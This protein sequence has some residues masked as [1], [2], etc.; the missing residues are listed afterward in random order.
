M[1]AVFL[2][3]LNLSITASW[4]ILAVV[5]ARFILKKA[6]K[7]VSCVLWTLV[8][9]RLVCPFTLESALSLIPSSETIPSNIEMMQK[10]AIDSG[11]T[12]IN[13]AINPVIA[14]HY[15]PDP[16]TS[17]N[18]LQ[19]IIPVLSIVW[20]VGMATMLLYALISYIRLKKSVGASVSVRDN[21]LACDE[22]KS[23]FIL[24]IIKPLIYVP[25]SM[26]GETLDYVITHE[27]AHIKR[28][29]HW[30]KPFGFLLLAIYWFN[31]LCWLA[32]ILLCRDIEMACDEKVIRDMDKGKVAEYS[33]ALLDCSFPRKMISACPLAFGEVGVK[34]RVKSVLNYKKPAFWIITVAVVTCIVISVCFLTNPYSSNKIDDKMK[35]T[36]DT[37]IADH[38]KSASNDGAYL[39]CAYDIFGV[40][41]RGNE[42][43]VYAWVVYEE[44][45]YENNKING[46]SGS[47]GPVV[48][49]V[50]TFQN[51]GSSSYKVMEYWVPRDGNYYSDDI[52][53]KFP[54]RMWSKVFG[55][56]GNVDGLAEQC[57]H[58]AQQY[59]GSQTAFHTFTENADGTFTAD[60]GK[61]YQYKLKL[62][63]RSPNAVCDS[64][65]VVLSNNKDLTFERVNESIFTSNT[66]RFLNPD[67]AIIISIEALSTTPIRVHVPDPASISLD[68]QQMDISSDKPSITVWWHNLADEDFSF[69]LYYCLYHYENG[70][71]VRM[72]QSDSITVDDLGIVLKKDGRHKITYDLSA[73]S[74]L[75]AEKYRLYLDSF[76]HSDYWIEFICGDENIDI[77][78]TDYSPPTM[79]VSCRESSVKGWLGTYSWTYQTSEDGI[80]RTIEAGSSHPLAQ[81]DDVAVLTL[82]PTIYSSIDPYLA[83][84]QF[85]LYPDKI[86][87]KCYDLNS[88]DN[89]KEETLPVENASFKLKEGK[90]LYEVVAEWNNSDQY[91]GT[92]C[93]AFQTEEP[94]L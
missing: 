78:E 12:I 50:D 13:E 31:P 75:P 41:N 26:K 73:F 37:A 16:L 81:I 71:Y 19:I 24:G 70:R 91:S 76:E 55:H 14:N 45:V 22:V 9:V 57:L 7:W 61:T 1:S 56:S 92:A 93:Y 77:P 44:Y 51:E 18:P 34:E 69:G 87:V 65:Y 38:N 30:W 67:E 5:L 29:D 88:K 83:T 74:I 72:P 64:C 3:L 68:I 8:A 84:L 21:I 60:N 94:Y 40:K 15:A 79:T 27:S 10:P 46:I 85:A 62:A 17:A 89:V 58:S 90:H 63:G 33:Q 42:T 80:M 52:K 32:Y 4:L 11:I 35:I 48:F 36:L 54:L 66:E 28:H 47:S 49:T 39:A 43:T 6:P 53:H 82:W 23:P 86:T 59:F 20:I 25:S 2:K